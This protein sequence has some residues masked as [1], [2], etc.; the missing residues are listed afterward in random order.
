MPVPLDCHTQTVARLTGSA[1]SRKVDELR[2]LIAL[3]LSGFD[4][5]EAY[6]GRPE[7]DFGQFAS[8]PSETNLVFRG[9]AG[10]AY[11]HHATLARLGAR[12]AVF[13]ACGRRHEDRPG[14]TIKAAVSTDLVRWQEVP[15]PA[16]T[17]PTD[18]AVWFVNGACADAGQLVLYAGRWLPASGQIGLRA[19]V[20]SDLA[21]WEDAGEISQTWCLREGPRR[22]PA[23]DLLATG[24]SLD[25]NETCVVL[26][27]P[28]GSDPATPPQ[29]H[30]V[31]VSPSGVRP[32]NGSWYALPDGRLLMFLRDGGMSLRLGLTLSEDGGRTWSPPV[33]TD[34][35]NTYSRMHC[36]A[37][38]DGRTYILGNNFDH[39]LDRTRLFLA[40]SDDGVQYHRQHTVRQ[41]PPPRRLH[42][43]N[44][45]LGFAYPNALAEPG[46]LVA[47]YSVNKEDIEVSV[48][49]TDGL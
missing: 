28:A 16:P 15:A 39:C 45:D 8:A 37:F 17:A 43:H 24:F 10:A 18:D 48:I 44:K 13:W 5:I 41:D 1:V 40:V 2:L 38:G 30:P 47:A 25:T 9:G 26:R 27:W 49:P 35:P 6:C 33:L 14:Q 42:G 3:R 22:T 4:G 36:G 7:P 31:P 46:R 23:G 20:T 21:T 32:E 29:R 19:F 11:S 12:Y 34:F